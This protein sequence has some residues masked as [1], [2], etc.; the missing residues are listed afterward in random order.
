MEDLEYEMEKMRMELI[1]LCIEKD[2]YFN[3]IKAMTPNDNA[4]L[5][6][7]K[8]SSETLPL[9]VVQ[10]LELMPWDDRTRSHVADCDVLHQWQ[11]YDS[12]GKVWVDRY[13]LFPNDSDY[14]PSQKS[15]SK[16]TKNPLDSHTLPTRGTWQWID[17]WKLDGVP[18]HHSSQDNDDCWTYATN[19]RFLKLNTKEVARG[20]LSF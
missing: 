9:E 4:I 13:D 17:N 7:S 11:V 15:D 18:H 3:I 10:L 20:Q 1:S 2:D 16:S 6:A 5:M 14:S 12:K 8:K 19:P